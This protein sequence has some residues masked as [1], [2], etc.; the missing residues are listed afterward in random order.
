M[1]QTAIGR[2]RVTALSLEKRCLPYKDTGISENE[3]KKKQRDFLC[4]SIP[5][6]YADWKPITFK[7]EREAKIAGAPWNCLCLAVDSISERA[8]DASE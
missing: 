5:I 2:D 1:R 6:L 4:I 3:L 8:G 7:K